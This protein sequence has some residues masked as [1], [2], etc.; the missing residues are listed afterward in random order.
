VLASHE[1]YPNVA[2]AEDAARKIPFVGRY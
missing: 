2:R 1:V